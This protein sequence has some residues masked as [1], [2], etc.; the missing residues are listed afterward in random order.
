MTLKL[1]N[2]L[3]KKKE[4]FKPLKKGKVSMYSC[5]PTVYSYAHLGNFRAFI[6]TDILKR[7]LKYKG[8]KLNHVMNITDVDDKTIKGSIQEKK[9]LKEFTQFYEREFLDDLKTLGIQEADTVPRATEHIDGMVKLIKKLEE[10]SLTYEKDGSIYYSINKFKGYGKLVNLDKQELLDNAD[11]RLDED[12]YDKENA[13]D[14]ALW[15][16]YTKDD[17]E[18]FWETDIGKGRPGWHIECSAMSMAYLGEHFDIHTGGIDL[19]FPHHTNEIAQSEGATGKKFVNYW[20]HNA[21]LIVNGEKMAKSAGNFFTLRDL[22]EKGYDPIAIRYELLATHYRQ[23][24]DFR[25]KNLEDVK[26]TLQRFKELFIKLDSITSEESSK[27]KE[28]SKLINEVM[29]DFEKAMDDDLNI[30]AALNAIF[31]FIRNINKISDDISKKDA[32][33]IKQTLLQFDSVLNIMHYEKDDIPKKITQLAEQRLQARKNK[34]WGASD[35][36][37]DEIKA[38][39][40]LI[41][42]TAEGFILKK[43]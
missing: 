6:F 16:A 32:E 26:N 9:S 36:L 34:D 40:Y 24:L 14:F 29:Q 43:G 17:G 27:S 12:E 8:F 10:N 20:L 1:Y 37:R 25:E 11:G 7:Y 4:E 39:G 28:I 35:K 42:D 33:E 19:C 15:K 30:A 3:T 38:K 2:T 13:R 22:L 5:G 21:H 23:Q 18:V 31:V 41:D